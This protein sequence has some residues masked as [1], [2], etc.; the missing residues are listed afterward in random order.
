MKVMY[1]MIFP[2]FV[3]AARIL[4]AFIRASTESQGRQM[5]VHAGFK[6]RHGLY[7]IFES[8]WTA[9][10][11]STRKYPVPFDPGSQ[12]GKSPSSTA[13][14]EK[15]YRQRRSRWRC[16]RLDFQHRMGP[17]PIGIPIF[18]N[19]SRLKSKTFLDSPESRPLT[20]LNSQST[21]TSWEKHPRH[22]LIE[23]FNVGIPGCCSFFPFIFL[24]FLSFCVSIN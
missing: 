8:Y 6:L 24:H 1:D 13:V 11:I 3:S 23:V 14:R 22:L 5:N 20:L 16:S 9:T 10:A 19:R 18:V 21:Q 2:S 7:E 17:P 15:E 4:S 12:A